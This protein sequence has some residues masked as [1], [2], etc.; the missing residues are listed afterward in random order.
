M[1]SC[2]YCRREFINEYAMHGHYRACPSRSQSQLKRQALCSDIGSADSGLAEIRS[3][4][5]SSLASNYLLRMIEA[6]DLLAGLRKWCQGRLWYYKLSKAGNH[7]GV[8]IN[9][10]WPSPM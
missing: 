1:P 10:F 3:P 8:K 4:R 9:W 2:Q 5:P 6:H 7:R